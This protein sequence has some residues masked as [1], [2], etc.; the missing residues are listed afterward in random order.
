LIV[1]EWSG[2]VVKLLK[3]VHLHVVHAI[4]LIDITMG[5]NAVG[6]RSLGKRGVLDINDIVDVNHIS[7]HLLCKIITVRT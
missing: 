1:V 7:R 4:C 5:E 3:I 6:C 2:I